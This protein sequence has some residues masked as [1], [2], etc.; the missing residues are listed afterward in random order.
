MR[1]DSNPTLI[2]H[3]RLFQLPEFNGGRAQYTDVSESYLWQ[4]TTRITLTIAEVA[5]YYSQVRQ[6]QGTNRRSPT[7]QDC[8]KDLEPQ[9]RPN[10]QM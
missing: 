3:L 4:T 1:V 9:V 6:I 7:P 5:Q 2:V 10:A 8:I